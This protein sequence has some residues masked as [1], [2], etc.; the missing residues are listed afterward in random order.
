MKAT[1]SFLFILVFLDSYSQD[2]LK[3]KQIDSIVSCSNAS[4][5]PVQRDTIFQDRPELQLKMTTYLTMLVDSNELIKYVNHVN[6]TMAENG[7]TRQM[8]TSSSFYYFHNHLIKVEEYLIEGDN[9]K[10]MDWYYS[11]DKPLYYTLKS[12]KAEGR[13]ELLL[14]ISKTMLKQVI[15]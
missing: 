13:A 4:I 5:V 11:D 2:V 3:I 10:N 12:D 6:T 8:T 15:K 9:K 1:F 14:T 7:N